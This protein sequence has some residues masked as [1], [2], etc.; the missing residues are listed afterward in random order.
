MYRS[1]NNP[2]CTI[3]SFLYIHTQTFLFYLFFLCFCTYVTE[4]RKGIGVSDP[5]PSIEYRWTLFALLREN[6]LTKFNKNSVDL[7]T[8]TKLIII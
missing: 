7:K 2:L 6:V 5:R 1:V 8:K 3:F 4:N